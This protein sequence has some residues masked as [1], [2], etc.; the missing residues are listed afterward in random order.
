M[1]TSHEVSLREYRFSTPYLARLITE[2]DWKEPDA[3]S[4]LN[5]TLIN[6]GFMKYFHTLRPQSQVE[7][8]E[9]KFLWTGK[10][11]VAFSDESH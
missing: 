10:K 1:L 11:L 6:S 2:I 8:G 9:K 5:R 4:V 7:I 3:I